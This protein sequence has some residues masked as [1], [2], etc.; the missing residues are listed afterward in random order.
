MKKANP[1]L[2][3]YGVDLQLSGHNHF[4]S[5]T[6]LI[7]NHYGTSDSYSRVN[8]AVDP[9]DGRENSDGAYHKAANPEGAVY[10]MAGSSGKIEYTPINHPANYTELLALG[11]IV[12]DVEG[13]RM[14]LRHVA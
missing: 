3:R 8:H 7:N 2:E 6:L 10:V 13:D 12:I 5:R 9:G 11:S 1:I 14:D 4:Y